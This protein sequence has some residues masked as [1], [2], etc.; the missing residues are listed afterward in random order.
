MIN[1]Y[2]NLDT[3]GVSVKIRTIYGKEY[4]YPGCSISEGFC[5]LLEQKTLTRDNI[6]K[7]KALGYKIK[8]IQ[9]VVSL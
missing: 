8:V 9:E 1:S 4:I 3:V 5:K 2:N 7:I 6:D